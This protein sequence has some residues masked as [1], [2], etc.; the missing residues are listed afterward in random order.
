MIQA[1]IM[2]NYV[3]RNM[4]ITIRDNVV[5]RYFVIFKNKTQVD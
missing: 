3:P 1:Y 2:Y 5:S 4:E